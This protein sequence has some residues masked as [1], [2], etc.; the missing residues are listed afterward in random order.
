MKIAIAIPSHDQSPHGFAISLANLC[1]YTGA[2]LLEDNVYCGVLSVSGTY[3]HQA[4]QELADAALAAGVDYILWLDADMT[5]PQDA[6]E[7]LLK[8][9]VDAVGINYAA[10]GVPS[11]FVAV[12]KAG[13]ASEGGCRLETHEHSTGLEEVDGIGFGCVLMKASALKRL[14][15]PSVTPWF[16]H[17]R[18]DGHW[19]GEDIFFCELLRNAGARIFVDHDL[20]KECGHLGAMEYRL[21]HAQA[22]LEVAA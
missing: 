1:L 7:R 21:E 19:M 8:H 17:V 16:Q 10:R 4:R 13:L 22:E 11:H 6:L 14:P 3:V 12:K 5:F 15:D 20:S 18:R 2:R 9:G